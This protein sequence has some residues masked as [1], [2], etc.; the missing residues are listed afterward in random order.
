MKCSLR[1]ALFLPL[2]L[3]H[4][5]AQAQIYMCKDG[6][7]RTITSDRPIPEC[8]DRAVR[9]LD[10]NGTARREIPAPLTTEQKRQVQMDEEKRK[11]EEA[12]AD[13]QKRNDRAIRL[14]YRSEADI[15]L[16]H[17]RSLEPVEEQIKRE[18][19]E[20]ATA[21]KQQQLAQTEVDTLTKKNAAVPTT[22][23]RKLDDA[24]HAVDGSKKL[25]SDY[26][27]EIAQINEKY[28]ALL[29]RYREL[30]TTK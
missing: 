24:D 26:E 1:I 16:A 27:A 29:K 14:R 10:K 19:M 8:A 22:V 6:S 4:W 30:A 18:K 25:I 21:K 2:I 7:G 20:L 28:A 3:G 13:E 17:K 23:Q 9:E 5:G 12:A 15:D 11:T